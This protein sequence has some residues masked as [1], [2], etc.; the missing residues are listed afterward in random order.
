MKKLTKLNKRGKNK[1]EQEKRKMILIVCSVVLIILLAGLL[2]AFISTGTKTEPATIKIGYLAVA[3][4]LSFFVALDQNYFEKQGIKVEAVKFESSNQLIDA[5]VANKVD[6]TSI[7]AFEALLSVEDKYHG[8]FKIFE[9][10]AAEQN[11]AVHKILV[12]K[13]SQINSLSDLEGKT[14]G[15]NPGSQMS[16][17]LK[18]VLN[19]YVDTSKITI[20]QLAPNLQA[21]ALASGQVDAIFSLEPVGTIAESK[22][23]AKVIAVNSLYNELLKPFPT[24]ASVF[25]KE[26]ISKNPKT[27]Q[28][29]I[30]AINGAHRFIE[31]NE[32]EAKKSLSQ[33]ANVDSN[34]TD[35]IG[36][37]RYWSR[38][39][40]NIGACDK[41]VELYVNNGILKSQVS[42]KDIILS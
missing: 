1:M 37:Y 36:I 7:V 22:G 8:E 13:D 20:V 3:P 17:F 38:N 23:I 4:D 32:I 15:T 29:Y 24:S 31:T 27:V 25:S 30:L 14:I 41:L 42:V 9:M 19:K 18:L 39:E 35:R 21:Q 6:G 2:I 12:K 10:A 28:K 16:V 5:L 40:I 34:L 33:Y 26:Y 11:T